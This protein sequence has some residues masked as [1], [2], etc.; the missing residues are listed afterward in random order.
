[1]C[2]WGWV[3]EAGVE[4]ER[5]SRGQENVRLG[6]LLHGWEVEGELVSNGK[7]IDGGEDAQPGA[8]VISG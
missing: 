7:D 2:L 4:G 5:I 3:A 6:G 8:Q 1:M